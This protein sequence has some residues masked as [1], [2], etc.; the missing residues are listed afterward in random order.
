[1]LRV[2]DCVAD[3]VRF[4]IPQPTEWECIGN[5]INAAFVCAW[6]DF[7]KRASV[8][9][10]NHKAPWPVK[11]AGIVDVIGGGL[12]KKAATRYSSTILARFV[13]SG[14]PRRGPT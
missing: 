8:A 13:R 10:F 11:P 3:C 2:S 14:I 5:Q 12:F 9:A 1:M 7:R 4:A 6:T